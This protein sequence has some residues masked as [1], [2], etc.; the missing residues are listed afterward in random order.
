M[1]RRSTMLQLRRV[2]RFPADQYLHFILYLSFGLNCLIRNT[3]YLHFPCSGNTDIVVNSVVILFIMDIDEYCYGILGAINQRWVDIMSL[4]E[5]RDEE[6]G[7]N[8]TL[9]KNVAELQEQNR[10][11]RQRN[12]ALIEQNKL[13]RDQNRLLRHEQNVPQDEDADDAIPCG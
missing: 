1:Y 8:A 11:S 7:A 10:L 13:L 12:K 2:S 3:Q 6:E 9:Q 4:E 5:E